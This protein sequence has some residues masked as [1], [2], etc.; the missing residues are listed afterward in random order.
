MHRRRLIHLDWNAITIH[1]SGNDSHL[2]VVFR[3]VG[4]L[5]DFRVGFVGLLVLETLS[6]RRCALEMFGNT[7]SAIT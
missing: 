3:I 1:I 7:Y 5:W 2:D 6:I 4:T